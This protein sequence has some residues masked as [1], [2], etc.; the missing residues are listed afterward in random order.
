MVLSIRK[1]GVR[2]SLDSIY[3]YIESRI[4]AINAAVKRGEWTDSMRVELSEIASFL[5]EM[6]KLMK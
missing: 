6:S 1:G 2:V 4:D 3:D 5:H